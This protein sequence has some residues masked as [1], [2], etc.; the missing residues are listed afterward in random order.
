MEC[1]D[2]GDKYTAYCPKE[3]INLCPQCIDNHDRS[4]GYKTFSHF[5]LKLESDLIDVQKA[6]EDIDE[7]FDGKKKAIADMLQKLKSKK[8]AENT[9]QLIRKAKQF[10]CKNLLEVTNSYF[11]ESNFDNLY[12]EIIQE[13]DKVK[14]DLDQFLKLKNEFADNTKLP[15]AFKNFEEYAKKN[16]DLKTFIENGSNDYKI[17]SCYQ[18]LDIHLQ[19]RNAIYQ[20][21]KDAT[22]KYEKELQEIFG[23][24][25]EEKEPQSKHVVQED[26]LQNIAE[27]AIETNSE[28]ISQI[29]PEKQLPEPMHQKEHDPNIMNAELVGDSEVIKKEHPPQPVIKNV[30]EIV[31]D[32]IVEQKEPIPVPEEKK[33]KIAYVSPVIS[34]N[35]DLYSHYMFTILT[36]IIPNSIFII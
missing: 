36:A 1:P 18:S 30:P 12:Q 20:K 5:K 6:K 26:P 13:N 17:K 14:E 19:K 28:P 3:K 2:H 23:K 10:A 25:E 27:P 16:K 32:P 4:H 9:F 31:P 24:Q 34:Y 8:D 33:D 22:E 11:L 35:I 29:E 21:V 7:I 15:L